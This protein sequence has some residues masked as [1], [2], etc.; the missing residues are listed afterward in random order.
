M[1]RWQRRVLLALVA[2][3][4]GTAPV[5]GGVVY[6]LATRYRVRAAQRGYLALTGATVLVG[7]GLEPRGVTVLVRD[8]RIL[9]VGAG[10]EPPRGLPC[11][12]CAGTPSC[13]A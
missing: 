10:V 5:A 2:S 9:R 11:W 8:G 7:E 1:R 6:Y 3:S 4:V 13:P 12:I